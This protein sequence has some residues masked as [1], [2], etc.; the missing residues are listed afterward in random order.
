MS[1]VRRDEEDLRKAIAYL[2]DLDVELEERSAVRD[3]RANWSA[4]KD[5]LYQL[6]HARTLVAALEHHAPN[7]SCMSCH[8]GGE[9]LI[10]LHRVRAWCHRVE[11]RLLGVCGEE[12][13]SRRLDE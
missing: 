9:M 13:E 4:R 12:G 2:H 3:Q 11:A 5:M 7:L 8:D 10:D 1:T 6:D